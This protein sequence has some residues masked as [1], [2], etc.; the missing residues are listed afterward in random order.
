MP[1][2]QALAPVRV[3][4]GGDRPRSA[5]RA[6]RGCRPP[7]LVGDPRDRATVA[8]SASGRDGFPATAGEQV[9]WWRTLCRQVLT[10]QAP[11]V[12]PIGRAVPASDDL[13]LAEQW[14]IGPYLSAL[15][16]LDRISLFGTWAGSRC[17][18]SSPGDRRG[19]RDLQESAL[20]SRRALRARRVVGLELAGVGEPV[21]GC[22][23]WAVGDA[24][25]C[26]AQ[27]L[28]VLEASAEAGAGSDG[29]G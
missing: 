22:L 29:A 13:A 23:F 25:Q 20:G 24:A 7:V 21:L 8:I 12:A 10:G 6:A 27:R 2:R 9:P 28:D 1:V 16:S 26:F 17:L 19:A 11:R 4:R 5:D 3:A 18:R 14:R 15:R